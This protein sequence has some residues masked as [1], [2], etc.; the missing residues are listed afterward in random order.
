M[1]NIKVTWTNEKGETVESKKLGETVKFK[2]DDFVSEGVISEIS[3]SE[4]QVYYVVDKVVDCDWYVEIL[5][6]DL[7][8]E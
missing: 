5:H 3:V 8:N 1:E 7:I 6:S 4:N 2:R